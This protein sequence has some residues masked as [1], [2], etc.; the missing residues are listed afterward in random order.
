MM[1]PWVIYA[2]LIAIAA[3]AAA[4]ALE[5]AARA[6]GRSTRF[7]WL[8]ALGFSL[9]WPLWCLTSV[10]AHAG[11]EGTAPIRALL[12]PVVIAAQREMTAAFLDRLTTFSSHISMLLA[13]LW[14]LASTLLLVR[15]LLGMRAVARRRRAWVPQVVDGI[16]VLVAPDVGPAV[17][18]VRRPEIVIPEWALTLEAKLRALVLR[19]EL[20]HVRARDT[21]P[22]LFGALLPALLPWNPAL[23]WQASR[24]ALALE[25][26]CDARVL[27]ES[28]HRDRYGLLLLAIAQRQSLTMLAP[29]LSEPT[30]Q[31]ERRIVVMKRV[32]PRRPML[33]ALALTA[34]AAIAL[35]VACS[36]TTPFFPKPTKATEPYSASQ[37]EKQ[38]V[39]LPGGPMARYPDLLRRLN[40]QGKVIARF[41]VD[42]N[43]RPDMNT[44]KVVKSDHELFTS[45]VK[46]T[47]AG[48]RFSPAEVGGRAV[49]QVVEVPFVFSLSR[50]SRDSLPG[51]E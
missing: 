8:A 29:A 41:V 38:A 33:V 2:S 23:W 13:I 6:L 1:L 25:V 21:A 49:K 24:L 14:A 3:A 17:V 22:R 12:P 27:R 44:F 37:V 47:L 51:R 36:I 35:A 42:A 4:Y 46:S 31:L 50:N 7:V 15:I 39:P 18:G 9:L 19:H 11:G 45:A 5:S 28:E 32:K 34:G 30:S 40:V 43:G 48:M 10:L 20:E 26:D 16:R